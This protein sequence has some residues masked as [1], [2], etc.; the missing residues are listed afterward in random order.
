MNAPKPVTI[1]PGRQYGFLTV[2][3]GELKRNKRNEIMYPVRCEN[4][5]RET[6]MVSGSLGTR[7]HCGC[8]TNEN[9]RKGSVKCGKAKE[10]LCWICQK[11]TNAN[12]CPW[13]DKFAPV[14]GWTA[15]ETADGY[16]VKKCPLFEK[17]PPRKTPFDLTLK[18][19]GRT[20]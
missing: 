19:V 20:K 3:E 5:G 11:A 14:P 15:T 9:R 7:T 17:D 12:L 6:R 4:C 1:L 18:A 10:T 8:L 2:I 13:V 16:L